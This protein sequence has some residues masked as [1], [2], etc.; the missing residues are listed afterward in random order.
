MTRGATSGGVV[1]RRLFTVLA[2]LAISSLAVLAALG[3]L[4]PGGRS[5]AAPEPAGPLEAVWAWSASPD[6]SAAN[7]EHVGRNDVAFF[8]FATAPA[9][10]SLRAVVSPE[11]PLTLGYCGRMVAVTVDQ[12]AM[13]ATYQVDLLEAASGRLLAT[14]YLSNPLPGAPPRVQVS[15]CRLSQDWNGGLVDS[16]CFP[17]VEM[18]RDGDVCYAGFGEVGVDLWVPREVSREA[19]LGAITAEPAEIEVYEPPVWTG[20]LKLAWP[21]VPVDLGQLGFSRYPDDYLPDPAKL[22]RSGKVPTGY[23]GEMTLTIDASQVPVF[24]DLA[25]EDG[26]FRVTIRRVQPPDF[27]VQGPGRQPLTPYTGGRRLYSLAPGRYAYRLVFTQ[28]MDRRSVERRLVNEALR[29]CPVRWEFAWTNDRVL[30]VTID[31]TGA[32]EGAFTRVYPEGALDKRGMP[33][34]FATPLDLRWAGATR[35]VDVPLEGG[36]QA[37]GAAGLEGTDPAA[38]PGL[39]LP[40]GLAPVSWSPGRVRLAA[41]EGTE[42]P[43][44]EYLDLHFRGADHRSPGGYLWIYDQSTGAWHDLAAEGIPPVTR[45][46]WVSD[47]AL[48]YEI[49]RGRQW[50]MGNVTEAGLGSYASLGLGPCSLGATMSPWNFLVVDFCRGEGGPQVDVLVHSGFDDE[51]IRD[52]EDLRRVIPD[53]SRLDEVEARS[54]TVIPAAWLPGGNGLVFVDR[55]ADGRTHLAILD[56]ASGTVAP[57]AGSDGA[58][59]LGREALAVLGGRPGSGGDDAGA[60]AGALYCAY[61]TGAA[62]PASSAG[63]GPAATHL[64][65]VEIPLT[66][67]AMTGGAAQ[68]ETPG[69]LDPTA[70]RRVVHLELGRD[71]PLGSVEACLPSPDG[72]LLAV[73]GGGRSVIITTPLAAPEAPGRIVAELGGTVVGWTPDGRSVDLAVPAGRPTR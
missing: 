28:P 47:T 7:R 17:G 38:L 15:E 4:T 34:W 35:L 14:A 52:A 8:R 25:G 9:E 23:A 37:A 45:V 2:L 71:L 30:D 43:A 53:V 21:G 72:T 44:G 73:V 33:L 11:K 46:A 42:P 5:A 41:L 57:V 48:C 16:W 63:D 22:L 13:N 18:P 32:P 27:R 3:Y 55:A 51:S 69:A 59:R 24:A 62:S 12:P 67:S 70:A 58:S 65:V 49:G 26:L 10:G 60:E 39:D 50:G 40:P 19:L 36:G 68:G 1:W 54:D 29:T 6:E 64:S 66:D 56:L 20:S 31:A 61:V